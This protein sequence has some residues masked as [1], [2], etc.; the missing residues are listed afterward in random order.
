M[1][2]IIFVYEEMDENSKPIKRTFTSKIKFL[3][4]YIMILYCIFKTSATKY[5]QD[6]LYIILMFLVITLKEF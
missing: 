4:D 6:I 2:V 5:I 3:V 1:I